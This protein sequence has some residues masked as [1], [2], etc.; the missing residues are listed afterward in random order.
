MHESGV[1]MR[2]MGMGVDSGGHRTDYV[3]NYCRT[4]FERNV[5]CLKGDSA[6]ETPVLK[7]KV[8]RVS[9]GTVRLFMIGV[10]SAKDVIYGQMNTL[11]VGPGYMHYPMK[12]DVYNEN[13]F[14]QLTAEKKDKTT[15]RWSKFRT[16][17]EAFDVRVYAMASLRILENEYYPT[18]MDWDEIE[19]EF[20]QSMNNQNAEPVRES[21][22]EG[23]YND[24]RDNY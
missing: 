9:N 24:W 19:E 3:Y 15:G 5:F 10:N 13:Y 4:R 17:N 18:G 16:R 11:E 23:D 7:S 8:S 22:E 21:K 14:N 2:I 20:H 1:E 6:V 12:K